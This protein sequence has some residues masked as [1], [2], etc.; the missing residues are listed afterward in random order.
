MKHPKLH[1]EK[2]VFLILLLSGYSAAAIKGKE[3]MD[4]VYEHLR[5][6]FGS[7]YCVPDSLKAYARG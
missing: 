6:E 5:T 1:I 4:M 7:R 2:N 3:Q